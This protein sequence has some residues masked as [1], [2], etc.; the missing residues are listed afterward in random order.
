[1]PHRTLPSFPTRRSF[2]SDHKEALPLIIGLT[3]HDGARKLLRTRLQE[4]AHAVLAE[5]PA[6]ADLIYLLS[7]EL[8][9]LPATTVFA[10]RLDYR[11]EEHT[12][13]LQSRENL[14]C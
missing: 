7:Q 13:E 3:I 5:R 12:S 9:R 11:S 1:P 14:V 2:R 4:E 10:G 6:L 8:D